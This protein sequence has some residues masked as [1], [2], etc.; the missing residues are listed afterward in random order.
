M[1]DEVIWK[2]IDSHFENNPQSLVRHHVE[3]Y[4]DFFKTG[5]FQIFREKNPIT[6]N[7]VYDESIEDF[8]HQ[9]IMY[10]GGKD[11]S[12]I[13]FG[14]PVFAFSEF[15][16]KQSK[17]VK[18]KA[19]FIQSEAFIKRFVDEYHKKGVLVNV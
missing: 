9:C 15:I 6:I 5:I 12:K 8:R 16:E 1:E 3:S 13:Y 10:F 19:G 7:S 18:F 2:I 17:H 4:N 11:G 14:K